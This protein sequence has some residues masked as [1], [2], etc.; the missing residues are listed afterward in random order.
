MCVCLLILL[1]S[2]DLK[3]LII[4]NYIIIYRN[5]YHFVTHTCLSFFDIIQSNYS[6]RQ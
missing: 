6:G 4:S 5:L 1:F 2:Y 3:I